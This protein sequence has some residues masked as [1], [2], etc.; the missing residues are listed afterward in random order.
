[1][2]SVKDKEVLLVLYGDKV[3]ILSD[4]D[5][6]LDILAD[7]VSAF[8]VRFDFLNFNGNIASGSCM[9]SNELEAV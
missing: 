1:L 9:Y 5:S 8:L 7:E 3:L 2:K 6:C 4:L